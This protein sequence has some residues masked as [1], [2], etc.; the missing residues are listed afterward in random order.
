[1]NRQSI[2]SLVLCLKSVVKAD[3]SDYIILCS[4]LA[5]MYTS[6]LSAQG[7]SFVSSYRVGGANSVRG[8][9]LRQAL[10]EGDTYLQDRACSGVV[11]NVSFCIAV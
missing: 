7:S 2:R 8:D 11:H 4:I 3:E 1:M 6:I 5:S 9:K 10:L